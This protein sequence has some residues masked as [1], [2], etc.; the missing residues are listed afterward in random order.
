MEGGITFSVNALIDCAPDFGNVME[1]AKK[2]V[3]PTT[4]LLSNLSGG[5]HQGKSPVAGE[6][7]RGILSVCPA[8]LFVA[9]PYSCGT[10]IS[11]HNGGG[12]DKENMGQVFPKS[13][14]FFTTSLHNI[15]FK[16]LLNTYYFS[17]QLLS[18]GQWCYAKKL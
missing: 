11:N 2:M 15:H 13:L 7:S 1:I 14:S 8:V 4:K 12:S 10:F 3:E 6:S 18:L 5:N 17:S 16:K 9:L